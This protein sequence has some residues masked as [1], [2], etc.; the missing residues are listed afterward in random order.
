MRDLGIGRAHS[1]VTRRAGRS[2][3]SWHSMPRTA[4]HTVVAMEA[5]R[6]ATPGEAPGGLPPRRRRA[7]VER[8]GSG[9][10]A[11]AVEPCSAASAGRPTVLRSSTASR[12]RSSE[13]VSLTRTRSSA[14]ELLAVWRGWSFTGE[15]AGRITQ[16]VLAVA[17][18]ERAVPPVP[19]ATGT[20]AR[21][22]TEGR[23][24]RPPRRD[25]PASP[26]KARGRWPEGLASFFARHPLTDVRSSEPIRTREMG[27]SPDA[28]QA[29]GRSSTH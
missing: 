2:H 7:A 19:R 23:G 6:P 27:L 15:D 8:L 12:E 14:Q 17:R 4:V 11:G 24:V 13:A 29:A 3:C 16:P 18:R 22:A 25:A 28:R 20:A 26:P 21:L 9:D 5:A 10:K 1:S